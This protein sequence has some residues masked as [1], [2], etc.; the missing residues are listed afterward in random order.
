MLRAQSNPPCSGPCFTAHRAESL[1][2]KTFLSF[3]IAFRRLC[4]SWPSPT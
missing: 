3:K 4:C 1:F 2:L